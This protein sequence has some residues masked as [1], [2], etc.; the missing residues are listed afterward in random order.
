MKA[1]SDVEALAMLAA[2]VD[3]SEDAIVSKNLDSM[4]TSWN[5]AAEK[6]FGYAAEEIVGRS[7]TRII[8]RTA[9][10]K[11]MKS[12]QRSGSVNTSGISK[13]FA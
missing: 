5:A 4:V 8:P 1:E 3:S 11:R 7:I 2:I 12:W 9:G 10:M 6:L 13:R